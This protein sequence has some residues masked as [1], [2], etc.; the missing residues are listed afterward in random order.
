MSQS[1]DRVGV[2]IRGSVNTRLSRCVRCRNWTVVGVRRFTKRCSKD[3]PPFCICCFSMRTSSCPRERFQEFLNVPYSDPFVHLR[4]YNVVQYAASTLNRQCL[5]V[6]VDFTLAN[7]FVIDF[8]V[9]TLNADNQ[10]AWEIA[11]QNIG[12]PS[13]RVI[14]SVDREHSVFRIVLKHGGIP[15]QIERL[16]SAPPSRRIRVPRPDSP[17]GDSPPRSGS[18]TDATSTELMRS[19]QIICRF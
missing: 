14:E 16:T 18:V 19:F 5:D 2:Y 11:A 13:S 10:T 9:R 4:I 17:P 8:S 3:G 7:N 15:F 6:L 12:E 1:V